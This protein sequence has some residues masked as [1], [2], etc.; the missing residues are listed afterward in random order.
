M[1]W[2]AAAC[3]P[4]GSAPAAL[5]PGAAPKLVAPDPLREALEACED[6]LGVDYTEA[7]RAQIAKT[8]D[9][10]LALSRAREGVE[11][12]NALAPATRFDPRLPGFSPPTPAA[13]RYSRSTADAPASDVDLAY[14][15][16]AQLGAWLRDGTVTSRRLTEI[17]LQRLKTH[18][19][20]LEA[21]VT[22]TDELALRQAERADTELRAGRPRGPLHGIPWVAK[23]LFDTAGVA[24]TWGAEPFSTRT[25]RT[26]ATVVDRLDAAGAVLL[27]KVSLGAL[28]YGDI[29]FGGTTRNPWNPHEGSSGSSAGSA[30]CVAAGLCAFGLGTETLGSIVSPAM[31]CGATGL[32]PTFGRVA[33]GG[34]MAL[35][36]SMDKIGPLARTT[37]DTMRVLAAIDGAH[38]ADPSS[39]DV[40][41]GYDATR[42]LAGI[43]IGVVPQWMEAEGVTEADRAAVKA[44]R[45]LGAEVVECPPQPD[46]PYPTQ[47]LVLFAEAAAAFEELT[48]S[49][50]DDALRWQDPEAWPN[51]FRRARFV[52]AIDLVQADRI[53]RRIMQAMHEQLAAVDVIVGPSFAGTMLL[54]TNMTGHPCVCLRAGFV[55]REPDEPLPWPEALGAPTASAAAPVRVPRGI[56][57]WG[58]LFEEGTLVRVATALEAALDVAHERPPLFS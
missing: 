20:A 32:R 1:A 8:L 47:Y 39:I 41:L 27:A 49:G 48:R 10:Q 11:I 3:R 12:P 4:R 38:P 15:S 55:Q 58:R 33:R 40:P 35:C 25:P 19:R 31:R 44:A 50:Q 21:V 46:L 9:A 7:E 29:W 28:A 57:L 34:A 51:T 43:R 17:Y 30:A 45:D 52:S 42:P 53:R 5:D 23:D 54:A 36:W 24:T 16:I 56:T 2:A 26:D 22:I 6:I 13:W 37:E 18:G 14:A